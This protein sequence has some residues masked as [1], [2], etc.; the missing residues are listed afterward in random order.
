MDFWFIL[1]E[2]VVLVCAAML[3]GMIF[4]RLGQNSISGYLVAGTIIGPGVINFVSNR[5]LI[6]SVAEL[7]VAL[8]LFSIGL[9]FSIRRLKSLGRTGLGG[10]SFQIAFTALAVAGAGYLM[11]LPPKTCVV[12]GLVVAPSS[13]AVVIRLLRDRAE[14][15]S[16]HG[17][18]ALGI[19]LLQDAALAPLVILVTALGGSGMGWELLLEL[20]TKAFLA[21]LLFG[22]FYLLIDLVFPRFLG[23]MAAT[24][25]RELFILLSTATCAGS[26]WAAH[27]VGLSPALGAF[28]AG[29]FLAE[30][31][32][33]AQ[34]RSDV[35]PF[36]SLFATI[37]F[38]SVGMMA[39]ISWMAQNWLSIIVL[40]SALI[41]AKGLIVWL[42]L[43]LFRVPR[44]HSVAAGVTLAQ[45][46]E[47]S[48]VLGSLAFSSGLLSG[49]LSQLL[50]S[51]TIL[52]LFATPFLVNNAARL[53]T[54]FDGLI[55]RFSPQITYEESMD[56]DIPVRD[57]A[58]VVGFGPAGQEVARVLREEG[59]QV[60]VVDLNPTSVAKANES[61]VLDEGAE[62]CMRAEI[63]D[64]THAE[65]LD[66][67]NVKE[68]KAVVVTLPDHRA[69]ADVIRQVR[70][71]ASDIKILARAKLGRYAG[72]LESAGAS[73]T[74]NE[75]LL[76]G[77]ELGRKA[78]E[79]LM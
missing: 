70:S 9:E 52:S 10:G 74:L 71:L 27:G 60:V 37:F 6:E 38:C 45:V 35:A 12:V 40:T 25:N 29:V 77:L 23:F 51:A 34:I 44:R 46:G 54:F 26:A 62:S 53:G 30:S 72:E 24:G 20:G 47:F 48:F 39:D 22:G 8:L 43:S 57:H 13:T 50:I 21:V 31:P 11:G 49:E 17:R 36:R 66:H 2:L 73:E 78:K 75:E 64:A 69:S 65:I 55:S 4:E 7:G 41:F 15:D 14:L 19:L 3:L 42:A 18:H 76:A 16:V 28:A 5:A 56:K 59:I 79:S 33:A 63:G 67:L 1:L 58:V 61:C 68:A 32:F